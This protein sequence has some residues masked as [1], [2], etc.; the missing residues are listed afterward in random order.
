MAGRLEDGDIPVPKAAPVVR[1]STLR[2]DPQAFARVH[3]CG[4]TVAL[5]VA[6]HQGEVG[7]IEEAPSVDLHIGSPQRQHAA[8][9]ADRLLGLHGPRALRSEQPWR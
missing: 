6:G 5:R 7:S 8:F 3:V 4:V 2:S 9:R 1:L